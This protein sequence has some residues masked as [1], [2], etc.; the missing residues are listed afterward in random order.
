MY[1]NIRLFVMG[2]VMGKTGGGQMA[3]MLGR[4]S[5]VRVQSIRKRGYYGDGG[6]LYLRVAPGGAKGWIF[7]YGGR[8]R[9]RDM[10]LGGYPAISL[11]KARE[12]AGDCR[13][14]LAA[15]LDPIAARNEK[16]AVAAVEA[17]KAMTFGDCAT[18]YIN[19]HEAGW[20]NSK[21]R[22]QWK[23]TLATYVI[24]VV[25]KLPVSAVDTAL[26]LKVLEPIWT[27]KPETAS[28]VR[29]RTEAVL[30]WAKAR[31]YRTGENPAR[32]RGH[33][34]HLLPAK[35]KVRKVEHHAALSYARIGA[36]LAALRK[37]NGIA[38]RALE[39][40]VLTATRTGETLG[41]TWNEVDMGA[42]LW[43]IPAGRMK[44]G[45]EYRVPLSDAALALLEQM[46]DIRHSDY[47]FPGGRDRR[48]LSETSL[49]MLLR[50]MGHGDITAHGFRSTFRD[51]A[52]ERTSFPR[53]VAEMA[54][55]HA[56]PDAVEAAYRR[57]DLFDK[58]RKLMQAWADFCAKPSHRGEVVAIRGG[59]HDN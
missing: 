48:P 8:D 53:E 23:N 29:G 45:K 1:A 40:L 11:A 49:L 16:R 10:G 30:D 2:M 24:P 22:Q 19:A 18:A 31:G 57:G 55:A 14:V 26:V 7:R 34:D 4:L 59:R 37:Q 5:A 36:F 56:I 20:R 21:H 35:A 33:L 27:R 52:A 51:W 15:G 54:L 32:W 50:R 58:R 41:G 6:G 28:R 25:G 42:K 12:L 46:H 44:A 3:R 13:S 39:F 38:A 9:R 17:A 47:V 43:T